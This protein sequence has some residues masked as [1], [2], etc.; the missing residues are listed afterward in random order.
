MQMQR[1]E[2]KPPNKREKQKMTAQLTMK[3]KYEALLRAPL[4]S[5]G[6]ARENS[7]WTDEADGNTSRPGRTSYAATN[8]RKLARFHADTQNT[9]LRV[10][11]P[12][13]DGGLHG[14][15]DPLDEGANSSGGTLE[16]E[17]R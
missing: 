16:A 9:D 2:V 11:E 4:P 12:L 10:V 3:K 7:Y 1:E 17:C 6:Q 14:L 8:T 5:S 13:E 15:V